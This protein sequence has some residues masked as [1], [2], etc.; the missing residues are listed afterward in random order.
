[1]PP[2]RARRYRLPGRGRSRAIAP[3]ELAGLIIRYQQGESIRS[4][5]GSVD[6]SR[7]TMRRTL[8]NVAKRAEPYS[9]H[10]CLV[11]SDRTGNLD[12]SRRSRAEQHDGDLLDAAT[13][14]G[15][16]HLLGTMRRAAGDA[17]RPVTL[18][19]SHP[20]SQWTAQCSSRLFLNPADGGR[21]TDS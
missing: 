5:A 21:I 6:V 11:E 19:L 7:E 15:L 9:D 1:M 13:I 17:R 12:R 18:T 4:L 16:A 14:V 8:A 10:P 20:R 2:R 3:E